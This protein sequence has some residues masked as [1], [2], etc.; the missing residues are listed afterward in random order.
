MHEDIKQGSLWIGL[1]L[2][3]YQVGPTGEAKSLLYDFMHDHFGIE[4]G[5]YHY[6]KHWNISN[7]G[8]VAKVIRQFNE[9]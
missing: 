2:D 7:Y 6:G 4:S 8:G 9:S 1:R 3:S 5:E